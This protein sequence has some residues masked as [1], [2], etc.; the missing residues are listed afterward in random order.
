MKNL[1]LHGN[2]FGSTLLLNFSVPVSFILTTSC[3]YV[4]SVQ[5]MVLGQGTFSLNLELK[6]T[7]TSTKQVSPQ[8]QVEWTTQPLYFM[9]F[10]SHYVF[11]LSQPSGIRFVLISPTSELI[12]VLTPDSLNKSRNFE[13]CWSGRNFASADSKS[14][15]LSCEFG[16]KCSK[17]RCFLLCMKCQFVA[18]SAVRVL[19]CLIANICRL[20]E[21]CFD[22]FHHL[23]LTHEI[24]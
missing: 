17:L 15:L 13:S 7:L 10:T 18:I 6:P 8:Q 2:H 23:H 14:P 20:F 5:L 9:W 19:P 1:P 22:W 11:G 24:K 16:I 21:C 4:T 3:P 12:T